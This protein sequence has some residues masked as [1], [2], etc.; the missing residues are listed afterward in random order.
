[1][2]WEWFVGFFPSVKKQQRN[3][4]LSPTEEEGGRKEEEEGGTEI[5]G[6]FLAS[7]KPGES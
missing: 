1:M 7:W 3:S 4:L 5:L 6:R 2:Q